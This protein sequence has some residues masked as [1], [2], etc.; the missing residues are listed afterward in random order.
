MSRGFAEMTLILHARNSLSTEARTGCRYWL[1]G[2]AASSSW[3]CSSA[4]WTFFDIKRRI[5]WQLSI[6]LEIFWISGSLKWYRQL[7]WEVKAPW[8]FQSLVIQVL[9]WQHNTSKLWSK[10]Q[11]CWVCQICSK[12][13]SRYLMVLIK[14]MINGHFKG[15]ILFS[16]FVKES[17]L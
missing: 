15:W 14:W 7:P 9:I 5:G 10:I 1:S 13:E 12:S 16:S 11:G 4:R 3:R 8:T 17:A 2:R 6:Y